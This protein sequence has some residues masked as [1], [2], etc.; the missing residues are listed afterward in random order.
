MQNLEGN[1]FNGKNKFIGTLMNSI[2][3][4]NSLAGNLDKDNP[5]Y[6]KFDGLPDKKDELINKH[7]V[8]RDTLYNPSSFLNHGGYHEY[9]YAKID[10]N[11]I[12]RIQDYRRMAAYA[13]LSDAIDEICDEAVIEDKKGNVLNC[14][15]KKQLSDNAK[16]EL[17]NE[18]NKFVELFDLNNKGYDYFRQFLIDGELFFEHVISDN[19]KRG[20][21]GVVMLPPELVNP[22]YKNRQNDF[23]EN[24]SLRRPSQDPN[25]V[26]TEEEVI[27]MDRNQ[28]T[29]INSG[30]WNEDRTIRLPYI[31]NARVAYKQLSLIEDSIIIYRLVRAPERMVFKV[32]VGNMSSANAEAHLKRL[33]QQYWARRSFSTQEGQVTNAYEPQSML[34]AYWFTKRGDS[35][36][37][38]VDVLPGGQNLGELS[39]LNYFLEKLYK[40]LKVPVSRLSAEST[41]SASSE[42]ITREELRFSKFVMRVQRQFA[43]GIKKGFQ[44]H[45]ELKDLWQ[46]YKLRETDL[47]I[48][49]NPP[50]H[51]LALKNQQ[52]FAIQSENFNNL[53][54]NEGISNSFSQ[55]HYLEMD[56]TM[57]KE[58]REWL[59]KDSELRWELAQIESMGPDWKEQQAEALDIEPEFGA[60]GGGGGA[61]GDGFPTFGPSPEVGGGGEEPT[62][63]VPEVPAPEAP[64]PTPTA[65]A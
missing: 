12:R 1:N 65:E 21:Q 16:K 39:D 11:K 59:R 10:Q 46:Q 15:F 41:T 35:E 18:W 56:D 61:G 63:E 14:D 19:S 27:V 64:E 31:E 45:L 6:V 2:P 36:G 24:Y 53:S 47:K 23:I 55:R 25:K 58:N 7:S 57:I 42:E 17:F 8:F 51:F 30:V 43:Q 3:Y 54:Q 37:T 26:Q 44:V 62:Q 49:F 4:A 22:I 40:S 50:T 9:I 13:E 38:T 32:D 20:I 52:I 60:G 33:M 28:I 34:D 5:K 29:Y 48:E